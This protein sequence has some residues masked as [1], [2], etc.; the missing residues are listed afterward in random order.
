MSFRVNGYSYKSR[1]AAGE[2]RQRVMIHEVPC[3]HIEEALWENGPPTPKW[4]QHATLPAA[5]K[6]ATELA[7]KHG[8][9]VVRDPDCLS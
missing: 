5:E 7:K 8:Y 2:P 1:A 9:E 4:T 3:P 6:K